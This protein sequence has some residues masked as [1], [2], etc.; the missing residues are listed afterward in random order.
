MMF[1]FVF[2]EGKAPKKARS[3]ELTY[4]S[5]IDPTDATPPLP[6]KRQVI[7]V[8]P[9]IVG[10]VMSRADRHYAPQKGNPFP[11]HFR[12]STAKVDGA[13]LNCP[14]YLDMHSPR[15]IVPSTPPT[16]MSPYDSSW[17][18]DI[19]HRRHRSHSLPGTP[20]FLDESNFGFGTSE[21]ASGRDEPRKTNSVES[22]TQK[23]EVRLDD[24]DWEE[25]SV[26]SA[27]G[28]DVPSKDGATLRSNFN[29][30]TYR[31]SSLNC[32]HTELD[33]VT[34]IFKGVVMGKAA[35]A[36]RVTSIDD[37]ES[38]MKS[39]GSSGSRVSND[40]WTVMSPTSSFSSYGGAGD[41]ELELP[42][43][44]V[45]QRLL[46]HERFQQLMQCWEEICR[47]GGG[48]GVDEMGTSQAQSRIVLSQKLE[49]H[50]FYLVRKFQ[51]LKR[52]WE[53]QQHT[54]NLT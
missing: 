31:S 20:L 54:A 44:A 40:E 6:P 1:V 48:S 25:E 45:V 8:T 2:A 7:P 41:F 36:S 17:C 22:S 33:L 13:L 35:A 26:D 15:N 37:S 39:Y 21:C 30:N 49:M 16:P 27:L 52:K 32:P 10:K 24:S 3:E 19:P 5:T 12:D 51:E 18:P 9:I 43:T 38:G 29:R 23:L 42:R 34:C 11:P 47:G 50:D 28:L 4:L 14:D 46:S 53:S